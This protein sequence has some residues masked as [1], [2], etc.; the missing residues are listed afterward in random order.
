MTQTQ[1]AKMIDDGAI[2]VKGTY[3]S[4][5]IDTITMRSRTEGG[6]RREGH[7]IRETILT[8]TDPIIISRFMRDEEKPESW[9]PSAKKQD[10]V[11]V[12]IQSMK[13]ENGTIILQG[14]IEQ[15]T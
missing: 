2:V 13:V 15:L 7:I 12:R 3:W 11:I 6:P 10:K 1:L 9:K 14:P 5:R 4:G 8:D